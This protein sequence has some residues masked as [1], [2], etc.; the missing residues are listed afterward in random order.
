[1]QPFFF[2][3][4]IEKNENRYKKCQEGLQKDNLEEGI[5]QRK[6]LQSKRMNPNRYYATFSG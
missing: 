5:P 1:M 4:R 3:I 2:L 6:G